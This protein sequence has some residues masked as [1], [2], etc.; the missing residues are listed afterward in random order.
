[1]Q[2]AIEC[3]II[4]EVVKGLWHFLTPIYL[5]F[6]VCWCQR[7]I[8]APLRNHHGVFSM[9]IN[10]S[11]FERE[12][13]LVPTRDESSSLFFWLFRTFADN[14]DNRIIFH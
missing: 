3:G 8:S 13:F 9:L 2:I 12:P 7:G 6:M 1:M 5:R 10:Y 4:I 14:S 11:P